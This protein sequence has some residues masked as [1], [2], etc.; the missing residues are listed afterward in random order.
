MTSLAAFHQANYRV[1]RVSAKIDDARDKRNRLR[2]LA[3]HLQKIRNAH[4][5]YTHAAAITIGVN[6][7][8]AAS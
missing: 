7:P 8:L 5:R 3:S 4:N 1:K 2:N 6:E